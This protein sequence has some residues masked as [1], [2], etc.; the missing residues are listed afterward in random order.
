MLSI[1]P[2]EVNGSLMLARW[3]EKDGRWLCP[4]L[5][6]Y[7]NCL[8]YQAYRTSAELFRWGKSNSPMFQEMKGIYYICSGGIQPDI[9]MML[10]L[11][12]I[13]QDPVGMSPKGYRR[14]TVYIHWPN[15][16][17]ETFLHYP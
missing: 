16:N 9:G 2:G 6:S 11:T 1:Y 10:I 14:G 7:H 12:N 13:P 8:Y 15:C 4:L 5:K 3:M 17:V